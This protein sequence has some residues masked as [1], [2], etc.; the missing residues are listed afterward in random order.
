MQISI[1]E[2]ETV[3]IEC[4][5]SRI[6]ITHKDFSFIA[7]PGPEAEYLR[8]HDGACVDDIRFDSL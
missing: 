4:E 5:G 8:L 2:G 3:I 7:K 1:E 6:T